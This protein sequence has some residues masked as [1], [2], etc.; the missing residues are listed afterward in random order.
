MKTYSFVIFRGGGGGGGGG[1]GG[2]DPLSPPPLDPR[3]FKVNAVGSGGSKISLKPVSV[4]S[5]NRKI[6]NI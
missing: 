2:Q 1:A 5:Q 3:M 4:F 6:S